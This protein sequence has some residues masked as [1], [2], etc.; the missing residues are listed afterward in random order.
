MIFRPAV[1]SSALLLPLLFSTPVHAQR[2][3]ADIRIGNGPVAGRIIIGDSRRRYESSPRAVRHVEWVRGRDN[4]R[5]DWHRQFGRHAR[6]AFVYYDRHHRRYYFDRYR[7]GLQ[8]I[9]VFERDG[10]FYRFDDDRDDR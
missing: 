2:V 5:D 1:L 3:T 7:S 4:R 9:R 8:E 6:V 10:R